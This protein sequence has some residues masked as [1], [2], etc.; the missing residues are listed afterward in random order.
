AMKSTMT[1]IGNSVWR[2]KKCTSIGIETSAAP[3]PEM[4][5]MVYAIKPTSMIVMVVSIGNGMAA[6]CD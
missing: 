2:G 3:K 5:T 6:M 1:S 4:P